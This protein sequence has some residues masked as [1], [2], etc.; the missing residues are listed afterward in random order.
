MRGLGVRGLPWVLLAAACVG[1]VACSSSPGSTTSNPSGSDAGAATDAGSAFPPLATRPAETPVS[2]LFVGTGGFGFA[3]GSG[4]PGAAAPQGLAKLGP[5]TTGPWGTINF[6]HCAGYWYG[7]DTIQG[8]SHLHLHGT[9]V[10]DY[11][12]LGIMPL[13]AFD[14][15]R[16]TMAGY[17]SKF[18]KASE[19]ATP[20]RYAVTLDNGGIRV[21]MTA[22]PHAGHHRYTFATSATSGHV[23]VDLDHHIASGAVAAESLALGADGASLTGSLLSQG[24]LSRGF[25]GSTIYFA[26]RTSKPWTQA[27]VWSAGTGNAPAP[28]APGATAAGTGVGV[29]LAF[30]VSDHAPV[31]VQVGLSFVS[32]A[33]AAANL[34][35]EMPSFAFDAEAS[36]TAAAWKTAMAIVDVE[37]GTPAAQTMM[38]AAVYHLLLM[39]TIQSDVDGTY[40][41]LDRKPATAQGFHYVSEASLWDIYRTL[42]PL[43]DLVAP[44]RSLDLVQSLVAMSKASGF[45][46]KWPIGDGEA[47]TM[48]GAS[49]EVVLADAY[50]KGLRGFDAEG[51]Y[52]TMRAAAMSDADPPGGRGGRDQVVSYMQ[53]GYVPAKASDASSSTSITIE[54][55]QDDAALE[56]LAT[57][58]G[59]TADA[60][61]L[62]SRRHGWQKLYDPAS[63]LL[64]SKDATGAWATPHGAGTSESPDFDEADA[65]QSV[66]GPW[67]DLPTL[68]SLMGGKAGLV[69]RLEAFFENGK[70]DYDAVQWSAPLSVGGV[71][72]YFWGGNE[73]DIHAVY[74]FALS[75]RPDLTQKWLPW[76]ESE[77]YTAGADGVPGNDD[78]GTMSAWLVFS[79][80]GFYGI[81][82]T[83]QYVVGAPAFPRATLSVQGGSFTIEA[84]G[85]SAANPYVQSVTLDGAPLASPLLHHRDFKAGGTLSFVMGPA[86][87]RWGRD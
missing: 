45:F 8:F 46:P 60:A 67:Y 52:Q 12:V 44:E 25:G 66:W 10:P 50:V 35:A 51:A 13:P 1:A 21:E 83:D 48:I 18:A 22:T 38:Q 28:A 77:V 19:Q 43:L 14:A 64:W 53:L 41:G 26:A 63:G 20:G 71:R 56:Q 16:T 55:A 5:D 29:D 3:T 36:A 49:A 73:P 15:T 2:P 47:G 59:H 24:G 6:L 78:A 69:S 70:A 62:E 72:K 54:Y 76:I 4:F 23:V 34:A 81:P 80:L 57:A 74:L 84:K 9:G 58:L 32:S 30:D 65:Q 17:Q 85:L 31:E 61:Q 7:D 68:Q 86:P 33:A 40:I 42:V 11:G 37:G 39:P 27:Q 82:G 75:G 87:S 79:M